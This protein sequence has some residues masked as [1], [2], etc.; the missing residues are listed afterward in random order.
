MWCG[1]IFDIDEIIKSRQIIRD[2]LT[3]SKTTSTLTVEQL[4]I[5]EKEIKHLETSI[6]TFSSICK[7]ANI[8]P[9]SYKKVIRDKEELDKAVSR[10]KTLVFNKLISILKKGKLNGFRSFQNVRNSR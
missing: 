7:T 4:N 6:N 1:M 8:L 9:I 3:G 10:H 5:I 2:I